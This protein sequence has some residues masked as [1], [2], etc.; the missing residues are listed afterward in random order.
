MRPVKPEDSG[1][2]KVAMPKISLENIPL[3][4]CVKC[5]HTGFIGGVEIRAISKIIS[6]SGQDEILQAK[7]LICTMC[8]EKV[9]QKDLFKAV[10]EE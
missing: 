7:I 2:L 10:F 6:A 8:G 4:K 1:Q 5:T 9:L 3:H